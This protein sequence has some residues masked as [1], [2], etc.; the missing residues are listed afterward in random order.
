MNDNLFTEPGPRDLEA[1]DPQGELDAGLAVAI[2]HDLP[3]D[4]AALLADL[5]T[6]RAERLGNIEVA[7]RTD[8]DVRLFR[9][10]RPEG[11]SDGGLRVALVSVLGAEASRRLADMIGHAITDV[12]DRGLQEGQAWDTG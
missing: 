5:I 1:L 9:A 10:L 7:A 11:D 12:Y 2:A 8:A 6:K 3:A 4:T